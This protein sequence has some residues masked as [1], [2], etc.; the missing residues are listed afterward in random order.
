MYNT[1]VAILCTDLQVG[2]W[3]NNYF[4]YLFQLF[5]C[6]RWSFMFARFERFV[7][8]TL[9]NFCRVHVA[10]A[11]TIEANLIVDSVENHLL[12]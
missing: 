4:L 11:A 7:S 8:Y 2:G 10:K 5:I 6:R 3:R 1:L 9:L 12:Q